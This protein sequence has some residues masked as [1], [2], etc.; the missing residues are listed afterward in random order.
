M[1]IST[2]GKVR[3]FIG[4]TNVPDQ[5]GSDSAIISAYEADFAAT[6]AVE[7]GEIEDPGEFGDEFNPVTFTA[8]ADSRVRKLKGSA[9]AGTQT[10]TVA[11]DAGDAG[12]DA[13]RAAKQDTSQADY[14][15]MVMLNDVTNG[16]STPTVFYYSGKVMSRRI[17]PGQADNVVRASI[18]VGINTAVFEVS[19]A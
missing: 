16:V 18:T 4:S 5:S 12:Q 15:F 10:M 13:L 14:N 19:A 2:S 7:I 17:Q 6:G 8:L 11:F 3:L 9:D 1:A